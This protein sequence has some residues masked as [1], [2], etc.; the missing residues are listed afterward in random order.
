MFLPHIYFPYLY[1]SYIY[2]PYLYFSYIYCSSLTIY[3]KRTYKYRIKILIQISY[4]DILSI[5]F[6]LD[7]FIQIYFIQIF[8][9]L[10]LHKLTFV[11]K[12][13]YQLCFHFFKKNAYILLKYFRGL[14][15]WIIPI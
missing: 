10:Y 14:Y 8:Q 6:Y 2:F 4:L 3:Y 5:Y 15:L 12:F 1:F 9:I 13:F 11:L 7:I